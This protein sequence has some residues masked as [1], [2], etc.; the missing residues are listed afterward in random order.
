ML[1]YKGLNYAERLIGV[2][3]NIRE[4]KQSS[5]LGLLDHHWKGHVTVG[6]LN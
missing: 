2:I 1:G 4:Q 6:V 5:S 3:D